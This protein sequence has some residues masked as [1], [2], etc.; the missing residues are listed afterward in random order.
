MK[1]EATGE[2][3]PENCTGGAKIQMEAAARREAT[4]E[5][6]PADF[7]GS[8]RIQMEAAARRE[9]TREDRLEDFTGGTRIVMEAAAR[10]KQTGECRPKNCTGWARIQM[11]AAAKRKKPGV[12]RPENHT[13]APRIAMENLARKQ[14]MSMVELRKAELVNNNVLLLKTPWIP[15]TQCACA[16]SRHS[17]QT[18]NFQILKTVTKMKKKTQKHVLVSENA[19][20]RMSS[21]AKKRF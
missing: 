8:A 13:G 1:R 16:V 6:R 20:E 7:L 2:H 14:A 18:S 10:R 19:A 15:G 11:E 3:R 4:G 12:N 17:E 5:D 9:E 21:S